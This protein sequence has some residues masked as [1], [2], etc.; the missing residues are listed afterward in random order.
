[1]NI[2]DDEIRQTHAYCRENRAPVSS[3]KQC[4]CFYCLAVFRP[5]DITFW[6]EDENTALCPRC[7]TDS[8]LPGGFA[9]LDR[10]FLQRMHD[11]W[12]ENKG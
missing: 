5:E 8:V 7:M 3:S 9:R 10:Q 2:S 1:V 6:L 11:Y 12:F 4:G